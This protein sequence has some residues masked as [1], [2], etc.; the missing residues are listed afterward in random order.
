MARQVRSA[1]RYA[2]MGAAAL[3][4]VEIKKATK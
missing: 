3:H 4:L 1:A 2:K